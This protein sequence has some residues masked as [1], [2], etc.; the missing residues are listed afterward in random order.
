VARKGLDARA[1]D[2]QL[3]GAAAINFLLAT[4]FHSFPSRIARPEGPPACI[5]HSAHHDKAKNS[6][7]KFYCGPELT[8]PPL[9]LMN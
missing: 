8:A 4:F 9:T 2:D 5:H 3:R 7:V 6:A 1:D